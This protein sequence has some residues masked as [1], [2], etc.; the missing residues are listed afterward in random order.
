MSN[1]KKKDKEK[2]VDTTWDAWLED[3]SDREQ[4]EVCN[5]DD[6]DCEACGS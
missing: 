4:P 6:E 5:I 2:E 1:D 3:M